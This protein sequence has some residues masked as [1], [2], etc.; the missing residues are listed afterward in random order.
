MKIG[1]IQVHLLLVAALLL[2]AFSTPDP[3]R[4]SEE[5]DAIARAVDHPDR[6][7]S[8]RPRDPDRKPA[9][10]LAFA[11]IAPG[12]R[13]ADLMTGGGWY[14]ELLSRVVGPKGRVYAHNTAFV[15]NKPY[16]AQLLERLAD[17][18]L[19]N[20]VAIEEPLTELSSLP[21]G[22]LDAVTLVL[23]YHDT[24]WMGIDRSAMNRAIYESLAPGGVFL[25]IDHSALVGVGEQEVK[26][27]HRVEE[28]LVIDEVRA[29]GFVLE[30][31]SDLLRNPAD[32]RSTNVFEPGVR[33]KTDRFVLKFRREIGDV[34]A[35]PK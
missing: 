23:F 2:A 18:R 10:V 12:M 15:T 9:E 21:K 25:V 34:A 7:E 17:D 16:G 20:V 14:A 4:A 26:R 32:D 22:G 5:S 33:G 27:L 24:Y 28:R 8:D 6:L 13:V 3:A 31:T 11:E 1:P 19:P 35:A 29:A 30:A